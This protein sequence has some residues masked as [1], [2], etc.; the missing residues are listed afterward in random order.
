MS[1][2][3]TRATQP[4]V[5]TASGNAPKSILEVSTVGMAPDGSAVAR[6]E[7]GRSIFVKGALP[8]ER[9]RIELSADRKQFAKALVV[10]V[11]DPSPDRV[12]PPCPEVSRGCGACPWQHVSLPMQQQL[13]AEIVRHSIERQG[14]T[15][16][17][18]EH[19]SLAPWGFRTTIRATVRDGRAGFLRTRS[20]DVV[21]VETCLIAHPLLGDLLVDGR[22]P[23]AREILLRCGARTGERMA[24][25]TPSRLSPHLP[26]DVLSEFFHEKVAGH[27]W[28]ISAKSFFQSRPDGAD[29]L[30]QLVEVASD[31]MGSCS[32]A[33]DL[34]SGVG[35][36]AGVLAAKGWSVTA[37]E[38]SYSAIRDASLNLSGLPVEIVRADVTRRKP[39]RAEFVVADPSRQGLGE[40]G[41]NTIAATGARRVVLVSCDAVSLGLDAALLQRAGFALSKVTC[42]DLFPHTFHV[43]AVSVFDR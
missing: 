33:I 26:D 22:Y 2:G 43:E 18:P 12:T 40:Q 3:N 29:A 30:A 32:S 16:P 25:T 9:V 21:P 10:S 11:I 5:G 14:V 36:F 38:G 23:G 37:V 6:D 19:V 31:E 24:A 28:R 15:C 39:S 20:H 27:Q 4:Q 41:V 13:K 7:K 1:T 35:V 17:T 42:V 34:Y 8:G